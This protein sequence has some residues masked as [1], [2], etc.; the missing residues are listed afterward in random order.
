[1]RKKTRTI[2][3][4]LLESG[5]TMTEML[6]AMVIIVTLALLGFVGYGKLMISASK[7]VDVKNLREMSAAIAVYGSDSGGYL[8][9][10][11]WLSVSHTVA[12]SSAPARSILQRLEPYLTRGIAP[13]GRPYFKVAEVPEMKRVAR[14]SLTHY[15]MLIPAPP[16]GSNSYNPNT[17]VWP[18]GYVW[19]SG[20]IVSPLHI[21]VVSARLGRPEGQI[22]IMTTWDG[23]HGPEK[24]PAGNPLKPVHGNGRNYLFLDGHVEFIHLGAENFPDDFGP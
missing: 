7:V 5:F 11:S 23:A 10:P 19:S 1:M 9:G 8:P 24:P 3:I 14:N 13:N 20:A 17:T 12:Y 22:P 21:S 16:N 18:F 15:R 6:V 4:T 2:A